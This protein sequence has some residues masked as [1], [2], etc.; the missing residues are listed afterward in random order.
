MV[1]APMDFIRLPLI[2]VLGVLLY[3]EPLD[4]WVLAGGGIV[5]AGNLVNMGGER[6]KGA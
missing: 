5:V 1:V 2:A 3:G 4:P 6:R